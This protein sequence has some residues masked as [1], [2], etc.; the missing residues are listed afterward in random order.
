MHIHLH[1]Y[2]LSAPALSAVLYVCHD[3]ENDIYFI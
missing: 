1:N 2:E 3:K